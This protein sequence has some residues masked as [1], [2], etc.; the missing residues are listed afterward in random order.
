MP[1]GQVRGVLWST[2]GKRTRGR[3][4]AREPGG[5]QA[6]ARS[7]RHQAPRP[8]M[9]SQGPWP[10][11]EHKRAS[12]HLMRPTVAGSGRHSEVTWLPLGDGLDTVLDGA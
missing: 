3:R 10:S 11:G 6:W 12:G 9:P 4:G 5:G 2:M 7:G 8:P 1:Q